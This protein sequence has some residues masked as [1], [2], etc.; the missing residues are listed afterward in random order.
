MNHF[1]PPETMFSCYVVDND[2]AVAVVGVIPSVLLGAREAKPAADHSGLCPKYCILGHRLISFIHKKWLSVPPLYVQW[3]LGSALLYCTLF[4]PCRRPLN[5]SPL[6]KLIFLNYKF[7]F[8]V[9]ALFNLILW[10]TV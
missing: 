5:K 3:S 8:C 1:R 9:G 10:L 2:G 4:L 7:S 6:P